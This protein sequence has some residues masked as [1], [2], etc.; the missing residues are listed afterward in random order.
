MTPFLCAVAAGQ[1]KCA[2]L[3]LDSG[4]DITARDKF[5]RTSI[6]LAVQQEKHATLKMLLER[7]ESGLANAPDV[8]EK[9]PLHYAASSANLLVKTNC[10]VKIN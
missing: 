5:Q 6:H 9:T 1:T 4:A 3:L 10:S 2:E 7:S 8:H